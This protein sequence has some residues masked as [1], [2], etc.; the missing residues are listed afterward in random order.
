ML[1]RA[2][3]LCFTPCVCVRT[4]LNIMGQVLYLSY[5]LFFFHHTCMDLTDLYA[6]SG[7]Q[8]SDAGGDLSS[9]SWL[10]F[11]I[12]FLL[13]LSSSNM[14]WWCV[15]HYVCTWQVEF[16]LWTIGFRCLMRFMFLGPVHFDDHN[17]ITSGHIVTK[18]ARES[19]DIYAFDRLECWIGS[20]DFGFRMG[21]MFL[22]LVLV[23]WAGAHW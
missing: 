1:K 15:L 21:F 3:S 4:W 9:R 11:L 6:E 13:V 23:F 18:L 17:L 14:H 20:I 12:Y 8:I 7:P 10:K 19:N 2:W 5:Y 22:E 16:W